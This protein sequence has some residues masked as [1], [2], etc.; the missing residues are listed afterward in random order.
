MAGNLNGA[1]SAR[2]CIR[3]FTCIIVFKAPTSLSVRII[4]ATS[5]AESKAWEV[6]QEHIA[7]KQWHSPGPSDHFQG[8]TGDLCK[9]MYACP[10]VSL[11]QRFNPTHCLDSSPEHGIGCPLTIYCRLDLPSLLKQGLDHTPSLCSPIA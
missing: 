10:Q 6:A 11:P 7:A 1:L 5:Q 9:S 4:T 2:H 8:H 3:H